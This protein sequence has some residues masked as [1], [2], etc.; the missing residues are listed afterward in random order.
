MLTWEQKHRKIR[1]N[2]HF[3]ANSA[4]LAMEAHKTHQFYKGK[5]DRI[6]ARIDSNH[7]RIERTK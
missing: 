1:S 6:E 7:N 3:L 2:E 4:S 5:M